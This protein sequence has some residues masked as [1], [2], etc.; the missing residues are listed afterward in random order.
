MKEVDTA[1]TTIRFYQEIY[2][3][4][5]VLREIHQKFPQDLGHQK[6]GR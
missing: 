2:D 3:E 1:E 4:R 6:V 5:G